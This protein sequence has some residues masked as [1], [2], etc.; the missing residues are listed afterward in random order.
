MAADMFS[1]AIKQRPS[2]QSR[3]TSS[4]TMALQIDGLQGDM[5]WTNPFGHSNYDTS[6]SSGYTSPVHYPTEA[7]M[8]ANPP[9]GPGFNRTRTSS[10]ASFIEPW[11]YPPQSPTSATSTMAYTWASTTDKSPIPPNLPFLTSTY[12]VSG[13]P[14]CATVDPMADYHMSFE[15][16]SIAQ[17]DEEEQVFMFPNEHFGTAHLANNYPYPYEQYLDNYWR[18]FH[19]SFP[20]VHRATFDGMNTSPMLR[21]A[22]LAIGAQYS[23]ESRDKR[24][25]RV[26]HDRARKVLEMRTYGVVTEPER[27]CD[28]QTLLL[29][30]V[31]SQYVARRAAKTLSPR[32][33]N[34][35]QKYSQNFGAVTSNIAEVLSA[36]A[37]PE[38]VTYERWSQWVELS[39]QQRILLCCYILESQQPTLLARQPQS[40]ILESISG[41]DLPF[42]AHH[43]LWDALDYTTWGIAAQQHA[44]FPAYVYS[45]TAD[46]S[47]GSLDTFQSSLLISSHY[48]RINDPTPYS[49]APASTD[50]EHLLEASPITKHRLLT[51]KLLQVTPIRALIAVAGE[52]WILSEKLNSSQ[53]F[54]NCRTTIKTWL[55]AFWISPAEIQGPAAKE[56]LKLAIEIMQHAMLTPFHDLRLEF[57]ADMGLYFSSLVIWAVTVAAN[58]QINVPQSQGQPLRFHSHSPLPSH[59]ASRLYPPTSTTQSVNSAHPAS[60][61]LLSPTHAS[62][63]PAMASSSMR[64]SDITINALGFLAHAVQEI[65]F[66]GVVPQW[67]QQVVQWQQGSVALM[68]WVKMRLRSGAASE[69]RDSVI[70]VGPTSAATGRSCESLGELI[71]GVVS[72]LEKVIGRGWEGWGI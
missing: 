28:D 62:P 8:F 69:A 61:G 59:Q 35:Y 70:S 45:V 47:L 57:G 17:R 68:H 10:N 24:H 52:S 66:L 44:H 1:S 13:M 16:K 48:N 42:P 37:L 49:S 22:I 34:L 7:N 20:V 51:A 71:D 23:N 29:L 30:E 54:S 19:P 53:A 27:L 55:N 43:S 15:P 64:H 21:A 39:S 25:S 5:A 9:Y 38:N 36:V 67:P 4:A 11:T 60:I 46:T 58:T 2:Y 14:V 50:I 56:A 31:L 26:L 63:T 72:V 6:S 40:S 18:L 3:H 12:P 41:I 32:F 65:D 33:Q